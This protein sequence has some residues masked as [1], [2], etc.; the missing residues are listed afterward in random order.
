MP[1]AQTNKLACRSMT[2]GVFP[3][4]KSPHFTD[5]YRCS[6]CETSISLVAQPDTH[7]GP[8]GEAPKPEI[9]SLNLILLS[10][11]PRDGKLGAGSMLGKIFVH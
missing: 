1:L 9:L 7:A 5:M 8:S 4:V 6:N 2:T 11:P 3:Y 10:C